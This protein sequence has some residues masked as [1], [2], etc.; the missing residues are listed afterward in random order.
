MLGDV[1]V[2]LL[3]VLPRINGML[4]AVQVPSHIKNHDRI[5]R[6]IFIFWPYYCVLTF[7]CNCRRKGGRAQGIISDAFIDS[8]GG[9]TDGAQQ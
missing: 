6:M 7:S 3:V 5:K 9:Y 4:D 2:V 1:V 8:R